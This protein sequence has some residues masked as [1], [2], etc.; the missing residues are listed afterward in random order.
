MP[1]E[2]VSQAPLNSNYKVNVVWDN[3]NRSEI[4]ADTMEDLVE[5]L[6]ET[7]IETEQ[8]PL[9]GRDGGATFLG[10]FEEDVKEFRF[11]RNW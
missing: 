9:K 7:S 5:Q 3:G 4:Y 1:D 10:F 2:A 6:E 8:I 11:R